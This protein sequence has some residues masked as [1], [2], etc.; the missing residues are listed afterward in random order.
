MEVHLLGPVGLSRAG[1]AIA[2]TR[3]HRRCV[4]AALAIAPGQPV[5]AE[6]LVDRVWGD[7][8]PPEVRRSL[9]SHVSVVRRTLAEVDGDAA[10]LAV[11]QGGYRLEIDP[12][13]VDLH[14]ARR[15]VVEARR[16]AAAGAQHQRRAVELLQEAYALW[17]GTPLAGLKGD[18]AARTRA[19]LEQER[20]ALAVD[21]FRLELQLGDHAA[22]VGPLA[23]LACNHPLVEPLA[24]L[25]M[26]A[27]YRCGLRA[28]ALAVYARTRRQ[29]VEQLGDEPGAELQALHEQVLRRDPALAPGPVTPPAGSP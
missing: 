25:W 15:R 16:L 8:P 24:G 26:L 19:G 27:L 9:Y 23:E 5:S 29:L 20:L 10:S 12:D 3:S 14:L 2:L 1:K 21:R 17:H 6:T 22:A 4:L 13:R 7:Q 18:W 28:D 11:H